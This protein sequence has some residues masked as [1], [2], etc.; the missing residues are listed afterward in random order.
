MRGGAKAPSF[1][2]GDRVKI[3]TRFLRSVGNLHKHAESV[4][5]ISKMIAKYGDWCLVAVKWDEGDE[6]D[7]NV[8]NLVH[9]DEVGQ[10]AM[11]TEHKD[12]IRG[13]VIGSGNYLKFDA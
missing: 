3:S 12:G 4:G 5:T 6:T 10:E 1:W 9:L 11:Q 13:I 2:L 7:I 8:L